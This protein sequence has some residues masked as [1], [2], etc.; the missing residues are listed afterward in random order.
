MLNLFLRA[1]KEAQERYIEKR[2]KEITLVTSLLE[3]ERWRRQVIKEITRKVTEIQEAGDEAMIREK[4]DEI[5]R[6]LRE[7]KHWENRILILG[8]V[9]YSSTTQKIMD[10][11]GKNSLC[12][13]GYYYF[14]AA[15]DLPGVREQY[16]VRQN[17]PNK[18]Q[19]IQL[20]D[21]ANSEYYGFHDEEDGKL[22][23]REAEEES[24]RFKEFNCGYVCVYTY[25]Y[26]LCKY[27]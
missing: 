3:C 15:R 23:A 2:P 26:I 10:L 12:V 6:L 27:S 11:D 24:R 18:Q 20:F 16:E 1:Q 14:G 25:T 22:I 9:D 4:N 8:G 21:I 19:R 7:K 13:D 5:N 17:V